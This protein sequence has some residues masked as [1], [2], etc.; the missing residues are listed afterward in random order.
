[1]WSFTDDEKTHNT[2]QTALSASLPHISSPVLLPERLS[3]G[4]HL[5]PS[6]SNSMDLSKGS[7]S[8]SPCC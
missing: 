4:S 2:T 5:A 6:A 8:N 1:M 3:G 7:S